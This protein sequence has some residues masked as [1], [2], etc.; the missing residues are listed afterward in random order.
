MGTAL[1][2]GGAEALPSQVLRQ[3]GGV[4]GAQGLGSGKRQGEDGEVPLQGGDNST[5]KATVNMLLPANDAVNYPP[6]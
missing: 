3:D 5:N 6:D 1:L 2:Q 4:D